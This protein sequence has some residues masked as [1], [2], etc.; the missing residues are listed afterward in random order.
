[1]PL[2]G[3][4]CSSRYLKCNLCGKELQ[5]I[6]LYF[7]ENISIIPTKDVEIYRVVR[8]YLALEVVRTIDFIA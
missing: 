3:V 5:G 2:K 6:I 4:V 7:K 1:M 8:S